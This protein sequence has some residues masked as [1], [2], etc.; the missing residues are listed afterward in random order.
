[1][2]GIFFALNI[3]A[4]FKWRPQAKHA[5]PI[6]GNVYINGHVVSKPKDENH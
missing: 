6:T 4:W 3:Y 2:Q 1:M 5:E